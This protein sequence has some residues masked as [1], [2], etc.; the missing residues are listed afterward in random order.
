MKT[1]E[2]VNDQPVEVCKIDKIYFSLSPER[3]RN[4][5]NMMKMW[6]DE[7]F[8]EIYEDTKN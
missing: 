4:F 8:K 3:K 5:L 7:Q 6:V 1:F 2:V